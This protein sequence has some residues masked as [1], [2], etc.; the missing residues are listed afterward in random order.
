MFK[1]ILVGHN[2]NFSTKAGR[3]IFQSILNARDNSNKFKALKWKFVAKAF[4]NK[5]YLNLEEYFIFDELN[6]MIDLIIS[7]SN[8]DKKIENIL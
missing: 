7:D 6:A 8:I 3:L 4:F 2:I 5:A 1:L